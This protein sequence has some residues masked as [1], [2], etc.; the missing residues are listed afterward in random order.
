V[1]KKP[2]KKP[3]ERLAPK[4]EMKTAPKAGKAKWALITGA[5]AGIGEATAFELARAG[6]S[7]ILVAR[8]KDRL[9]ALKKTLTMK[10]NVQVKTAVV[11]VTRNGQV[12]EFV[13]DFKSE[14]KNLELLVNSAGLAKGTATFQNADTS[15]WDVMIDTN[16]KGLL[17]FTRAVLPFLV[18]KKAGHIINVGSVAGRWVY[19]GGSVYCASK[20][21]VRAISEGLRM[22]L[23]GQNIRISNIEPGMVQTEFSLVRYGDPDKAKLVYAGMKPLTAHDI[24]ETIAWVVARPVHVNIQELVIYP[25]E[26]ASVRDVYRT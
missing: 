6:F 16:V 3:S 9:E 19:P 10:F 22:D 8:R 26:Q 18:A 24:A 17:Y 2:A 7:L 12:N 4:S 5:S 15:D 20:F 11:D 1:A 14:L 13:A 23:L 25:T 21:A